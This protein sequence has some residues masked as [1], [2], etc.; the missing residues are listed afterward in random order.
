MPQ[1]TEKRSMTVKLF[2]QALL[3]PPTPTRL[4]LTP[5]QSKCLSKA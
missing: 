4:R 1:V 3:F 2:I 5:E